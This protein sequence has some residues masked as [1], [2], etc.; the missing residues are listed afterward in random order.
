MKPKDKELG[1]QLQCANDE[2][3][4]AY[5]TTL[6]GW[7]RALDL[8]GLRDKE[9]AGHTQR[10][11]EL[12]VRIAQ[13]MGISDDDLIHIRRGALLHDI[14]KLGIPDEILNKSESL[15]DEELAI[16]HKHPVYARDLLSPISF[17][18][19]ALDIPSSY[20]ERWDGTGYPCGLKG[21]EIPLAARIFA[22]ANVF[23]TLSSERPY[24][25]KLS[26]EEIREYIREQAGKAFDPEVVETLIRITN[27]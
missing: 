19:P 18:R 23:D 13:E 5:D 2:L 8:R 12:A 6:E 17:L 22:V 3:S 14:G 20:M 9:T 21:K 1:Q 15:S 4:L 24:R 27:Q 10:V 7:L 25:S 11:T 26:G 16:M